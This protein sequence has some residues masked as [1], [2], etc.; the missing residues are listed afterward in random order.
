MWC[1]L[2]VAAG[3]GA[4]PCAAGRA[5]CGRA[6]Q[7]TGFSKK[8]SVTA[9]VT[10]NGKHERRRRGEQA[11]VAVE[12]RARASRRGRPRRVRG[13]CTGRKRYRTAHSL[14]VKREAF[15]SLRGGERG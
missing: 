10:S 15:I 12:R 9:E 4:R 11:A 14:D 7:Q 6:P 1:E 8:E 5:A 3:R 13:N 2:A